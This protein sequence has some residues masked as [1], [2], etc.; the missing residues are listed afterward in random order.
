M[1]CDQNEV[2]SMLETLDR[3]LSIALALWVDDAFKPALR[4]AFMWATAYRHANH[5]N[6]PVLTMDAPQ[7]NPLQDY[8]QEADRH[9]RNVM[10]MRNE[11]PLHETWL[12][13][14]AAFYDLAT[15]EHT[16]P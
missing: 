14:E 5:R 4:R 9:T 10:R 2:T 3:E 1:M 12:Y 15:G 13:I 7:N 6:M 8:F 16:C 11:R